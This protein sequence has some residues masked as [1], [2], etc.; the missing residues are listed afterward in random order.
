MPEPTKDRPGS[1]S[2]TQPRAACPPWCATGHGVHLGEDDWVHLGE[3]VP[4]TE[5][6]S[7]QLC[8]TIDPSATIEDGPYVVVGSSEYTLPEAQALG[9]SLM[10]MAATGTS[11]GP[12]T[13]Q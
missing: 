6:V 10:A 12:R 13:G 9:A 8:M 2:E 3:P 5:G 4:L 7:A 1:V 11:S